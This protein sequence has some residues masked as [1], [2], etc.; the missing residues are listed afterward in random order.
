MTSSPHDSPQVCVVPGRRR[1][2]TSCSWAIKVGP[3]L[4]VPP[5]GSAHCTLVAA[6]L[7]SYLSLGHASIV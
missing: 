1:S 7:T 3:A 4:S 2:R 6:K 5:D